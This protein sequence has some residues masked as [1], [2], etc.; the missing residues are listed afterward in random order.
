MEGGDGR[1]EESPFGLTSGVV[2]PV[3]LESTLSVPALNVA[4]KPTA[5]VGVEGQEVGGKRLGLGGV[6]LRIRLLRLFERR[7]P[8][9]KGG[10][11]TPSLSQEDS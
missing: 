8:A 3:E 2:E 1:R 9:Q 5:C 10:G 4:P 7:R 11:L 6:T